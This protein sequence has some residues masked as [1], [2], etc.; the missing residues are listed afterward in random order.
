MS[1]WV[2]NKNTLKIQTLILE[3]LFKNSIYYS[4]TYKIRKIG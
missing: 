1:G 4:N 3:R 2:G